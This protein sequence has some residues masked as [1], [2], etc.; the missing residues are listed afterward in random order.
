MVVSVAFVWHQSHEASS[1]DRRSYCVLADRGAASFATADNFAVAIGELLQQ[2]DV[3]VIN[4]SR[5]WPF[6]IDEKR[7]L[8]NSLRL[9]FWFTA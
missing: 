1:L 7:I 6:A 9:E 8:A 4:V 5:A 3:F 2:L